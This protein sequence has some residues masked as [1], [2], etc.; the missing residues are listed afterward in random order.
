MSNVQIPKGEFRR[1]IQY[2]GRWRHVYI[3]SIHH[4]LTLLGKDQKMVEYKLSKNTKISHMAEREK[5]FKYKPKTR[6]NTDRII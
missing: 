2:E 6:K 3:I 4:Q 5:F 1:Y